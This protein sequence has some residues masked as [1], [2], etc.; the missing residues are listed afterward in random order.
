[1]ALGLLFILSSSG[2]TAVYFI[3]TQPGRRKRSTADDLLGL[4][5][6]RCGL[7]IVFLFEYM[8]LMGSN[9]KAM[10]KIRN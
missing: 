4:E 5:T 10:K 1:L 6:K 7:S 2:E 8:Y 9:Q 3:Q